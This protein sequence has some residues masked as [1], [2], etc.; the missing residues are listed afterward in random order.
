MPS[1]PDFGPP[2]TYRGEC[3][4]Y[5]TYSHLCTLEKSC[6]DLYVSPDLAL[7]AHNS[8][9]EAPFPSALFFVDLALGTNMQVRWGFL[10]P[11]LVPNLWWI[12]H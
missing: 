4:R 1:M 8:S 2:G 6:L 9:S 3:T 7:A 12:W 10:V 11:N 5:L